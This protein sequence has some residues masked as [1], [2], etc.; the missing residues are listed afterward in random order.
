MN[1]LYSYVY[2]YIY[3]YTYKYNILA[4]G[5][6]GFRPHL[7]CIYIYTTLTSGLLVLRPHLLRRP[8]HWKDI[9]LHEKRPNI[10]LPKTY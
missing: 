4:D 1:I 6:L 8:Q 9:Y 2:I 5:L 3:I 7:I 10:N